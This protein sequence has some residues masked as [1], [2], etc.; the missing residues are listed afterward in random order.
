MKIELTQAHT[1][2]DRNTCFV[3]ARAA[4]IPGDPPAVVMTMHPLRLTGTD[5]FYAV[6]E[7][8]TEDGGKTWTEPVVHSAA[9]GRRPMGNDEEE[10]I[11]D[12]YPKWHENTGVVLNVGSSVIYTGDRFLPHP[13]PAAPAYTVYHADAH[14]WTPWKTLSFPDPKKFAETNAGSCQRLDL[15]NGDILQPVTFGLP[16]TAGYRGIDQVQGVSTVVRCTFDG[17]TLKYVEHGAELTIRAGGGFDEPS[18][19]CVKGRYYLTLRNDD[20]GYVA[21]GDDGLQY[22]TPIP[23]R[24]DDGAN[25]GNYSTQQHWVTHNDE[26]YLVYNRRGANNNHIFRHRA[27]LFIG[28]VD[29]DRLCVIR[30]T[31]QILVP[32]RGARLGNF[33]VTEISEN[34]VWVIVAEWMQCKLPDWWKPRNCE[35]YGSDNTIFVAKLFFEE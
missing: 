18:I 10:E 34:E 31:E 28:K 24:F 17:E 20:T 12:L 35:R 26:L 14:K 27:P 1:G 5:V 13:R 9:L 29:T 11:A 15:P 2:Y 6:N 22:D 25:L 4:A 7:I 16:E 30:D 8:R 32:E 3:H 19:T 21:A 33:G 23:W